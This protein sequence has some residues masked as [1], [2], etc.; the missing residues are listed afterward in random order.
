VSVS[1]RS[2]RCDP[3]SPIESSLSQ[4]RA[5]LWPVTRNY[6]YT[7]PPFFSPNM[8]SIWGSCLSYTIRSLAPVSPAP[9]PSQ[10][11]RPSPRLTPRPSPRLPPRLPPRPPPRLHPGLPPRLPSR[12]P[13]RLP[14]RWPL[15]NQ[16]G[17]Y[18]AGTCLRL[19][20]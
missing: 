2:H 11:P 6:V 4:M 17:T 13:S 20:Q 16:G 19:L 15:T 3:D 14:P 10:S 18:I 8:R 1:A 5:E 9:T 7:C 12:L